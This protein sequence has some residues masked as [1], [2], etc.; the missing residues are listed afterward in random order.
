MTGWNSMNR[1]YGF[2]LQRQSTNVNTAHLYIGIETHLYIGIET[3]THTQERARARASVQSDQ[4]IH[5]PHEETMH[6]ENTPIQIYWKILP[7]KNENFQIKNAYILHISD[8]NRLWYSLD[9]GTR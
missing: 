5:C 6:Y 4:C 7:P 3:H 1:F 9:C 2:T 8:Q